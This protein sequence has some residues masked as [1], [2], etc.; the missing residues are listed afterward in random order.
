MRG[1]FRIMNEKQ[2]TERDCQ[3]ESGLRQGGFLPPV[4]QS[5]Y[6]PTI[7]SI[8]TNAPLGKLETS[9]VDLAGLYSEK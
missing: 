3:G 9:T 5:I 4:F 1:K 2:K 8:S 6:K 7:A